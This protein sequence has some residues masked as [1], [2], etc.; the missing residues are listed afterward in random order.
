MVNTVI[1]GAGPYGLSL[2]AHFRHQGIRFRIFGR[3]MD[4]WI[5]HMPRGMMLKSDGFASNIYDPNGEFTLEHYCEMKGIRYAD[6]GIPVSLET[7]SGYGLAFRDRIVPE[8]EEKTIVSIHR[9]QEGFA[10]RVDD[11]ESFTSRRIILAVGITHFDYTP[12]NLSNLGSEF[13]S[14]SS[15]HR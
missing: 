13:L 7:F 15:R 9:V 1:I 4:S 8:L 3:V 11:G 5:A 12:E 6:S 2:A 10:L 14:H